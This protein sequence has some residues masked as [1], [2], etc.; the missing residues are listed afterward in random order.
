MTS[1]GALRI[2]GAAALLVAAA[3]AL[4]GSP[5]LAEAVKRPFHDLDESWFDERLKDGLARLTTGEDWSH[6]APSGRAQDY[7]WLDRAP[8]FVRVAHALGDSGGAEPNSAAA[9]ARAHADGFHL[10]EVDI[11]L[12]DGQ[13]R[14]AHDPD[15]V[16]SARPG[17]CYFES[18]LEQLPKDGAWLVL[19]IKTDFK[20]TGQRIVDT[21]RRTGRAHQVIFQLY[22][23]GDVALF[24][25]W[26][27]QVALPGPIVTAYLARR[28]IHDVADA[29]WRAG[30][31]ALTLPVWRLPALRHR[32]APSGLQLFVHPVHDCGAWQQALDAHVRG[33]Y[34][35]TELRCP[36][37]SLGRSP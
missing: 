30:I 33:I 4:S 7:A 2:V 31:H 29:A 11:S 28:S 34:T 5:G 13:L 36:K 15:A 32:A 26:Q 23:P 17:D 1:R 24:N 20:T 6:V 27:A 22:Q 14:C 3:L 16:T 8:A 9:L 25:E 19:D 35:V 37:P 21:L 12:V 18:L 10:F